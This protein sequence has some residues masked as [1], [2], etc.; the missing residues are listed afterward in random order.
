MGIAGFERASSA[1]LYQ[2]ALIPVMIFISQTFL[3]WR[4]HSIKS[5][6]S[7]VVLGLGIVAVIFSIVVSS[8]IL[9]LHR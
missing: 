5:G 8:A 7:L 9:N 4:V 2:F 6:L 1:Q 3:A